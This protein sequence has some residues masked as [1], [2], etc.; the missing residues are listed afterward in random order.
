MM[1][2]LKKYL[3]AGLL[4]WLPIGLTIWIIQLV[5]NAVDQLLPPHI[6]EHLFG[7]S[8]PGLG[9]ITALL[10]LITTGLITTNLIGQ[11]VLI[12]WD[13]LLMQIPIVKSIY[14]GIKQ[15]SDTLLSSN[16]NAFRKAL[17]VRFPNSSAWTIAF[18]TGNTSNNL[19]PNSDEYLN[20]YVP[21]TPNPTSGYFIIVH[22]DDTKEINMTVDQALRYVISMGSVDPTQ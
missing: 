7:V 17:L 10:L 12:L 5:I 9:L 15:V 18:I 11:K 2:K 19:F 13:R 8:V 16:G 3:F 20:V 1:K 4:V 14:K 21:T 22:K 6:A